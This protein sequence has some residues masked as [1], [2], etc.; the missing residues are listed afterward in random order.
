MIGCFGE[1]VFEVSSEKVLTFDDFKLDVK[2]RYARHELINREPILEWLGA[3]TKKITLTVTLTALLNVKPAEEVQKVQ[4]M[5][6]DGFADWL[7]VG[8]SVVGDTQWVI[9]DCSTKA[10]AWDGEGNMLSATLDLTFESYVAE[11]NET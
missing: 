9:T 3:D 1:L 8:N 7:I 4:Q 5:C 2:S 11:V 6:L 10:T